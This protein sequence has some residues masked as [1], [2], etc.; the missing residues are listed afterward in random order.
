MPFPTHPQKYESEPLVTPEM[1]REYRAST[2][3]EGGFSPP[4]AVILCYSPDL[5]DDFT[6]RHTGQMVDQYMGDLYLLTEANHEVGVLGNFGIGAP[7]TA[8][9]MEELIADG[10]ETFLSI[11]Y[12]GCLDDSIEM[13]EII[14]CDR[15]IRDDGTSHHYLPP[16][17]P[18]RPTASLRRDIESRLR[19][20]GESIHV[21]PTWTIDA[22]FQETT[23]EL[24]RYAREGVLTVEMEAAT[25]FTVA[26]YRDVEAASLFVVSDY[27]TR[28]AWEPKFHEVQQHLNR[29]GDL[30]TSMLTQ[31]LE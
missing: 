23:A 16:D 10:V 31:R 20:D 7:T 18:A 9:L 17:E 29:L 13:G 21:G 28:D 22:V 6:G 24:D 27:L 11:G 12:A 19:R 30:A 3:E 5:M 1:S 25:V 4:E 2:G 15:A 14:V 8:M 26:E